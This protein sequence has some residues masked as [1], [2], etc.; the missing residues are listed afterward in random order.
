MYKRAQISYLKFLFMPPDLS[1]S[2]AKKKQV[3]VTLTL[4]ASGLEEVGWLRLEKK[5]D[6]VNKVGEDPDGAECE[7]SPTKTGTH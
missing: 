7:C 6:L 2:V 4:P 3:R 5:L 1:E